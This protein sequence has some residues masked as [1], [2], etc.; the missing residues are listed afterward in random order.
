MPSAAEPNHASREKLLA[1]LKAIVADSE[2]LLK[3]TTGQ[4]GEKLTEVRSRLGDPLGRAKEQFADAEHA[5]R[6]K[7]RQVAHATDDY[8][9]ANPWQS[10]GIAAGVAFLLGMLAGR[11]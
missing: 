5:L 11:R 4:A 6:E 10:V 8:V 2:E 3:L 9:H 1:D 7:T